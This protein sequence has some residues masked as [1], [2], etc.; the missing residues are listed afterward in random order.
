MGNKFKVMEMNVLFEVQR[1]FAGATLSCSNKWKKHCHMVLRR[2]FDLSKRGS[3]VTACFL[4]EAAAVAVHA[5]SLKACLRRA[6]AC[7]SGTQIRFWVC[8]YCLN[9]ATLRCLCRCNVVYSQQLPSQR[10]C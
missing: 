4:G 5:S 10:Q 7:E 6:T 9:K 1:A 2:R 8:M 3:G